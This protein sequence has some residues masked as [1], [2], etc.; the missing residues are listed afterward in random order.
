MD[1]WNR[2]RHT[3][4]QWAQSPLLFGAQYFLRYLKN[5]TLV[6]WV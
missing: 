3:N 5:K 1:K 2:T 6:L 4:N